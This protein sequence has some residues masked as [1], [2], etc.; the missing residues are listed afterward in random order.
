MS[1]REHIRLKAQSFFDDLWKRGDPWELETS[2]FE[3]ERYARLI[4][5]LDQR[6]YE[7]VLEIGCGAGTFTRLLAGRAERVLAIDISPRAIATAQAHPDLKQVEFRVEN[8]M[9]YNVK[10]NGPWDLIVMSE[11]IYYLGWLYS[12]FDISWLASEMFAATR[13]GGQFLLANTQGV[14]SEPLLLPWIIRTYRDLLLNVGY[15]LTAEEIFHGE[16]R[17]VGLEVLISVLVKDYPTTPDRS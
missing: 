2:A 8:I 7:R 12:F 14:A 16:K 10:E 11:T 17:G 9:D 6:R 1:D 13:P 15:R 3:R 4:A 5:M